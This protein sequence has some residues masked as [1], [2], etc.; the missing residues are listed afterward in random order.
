MLQGEILS[1]SSEAIHC[2]NIF[3]KPAGNKGKQ[4]LFLEELCLHSLCLLACAN[5]NNK[6][7]DERNYIIDSKEYFDK[8]QLEIIFL[9]YSSL[10]DHTK[11]S[12]FLA[13][14]STTYFVSKGVRPIK[15]N[16]SS[17]LY[18]LFRPKESLTRAVGALAC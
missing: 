1:L 18:S 15:E 16:C 10:K 2:T 6:M 9:S 7:L 8:L 14:K 13:R 17:A 4:C 3:D 11:G 5:E 12:R